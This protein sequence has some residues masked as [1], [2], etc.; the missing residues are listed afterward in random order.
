MGG[1]NL[2][3]PGSHIGATVALDRSTLLRVNR[4]AGI[5]S[6][7]IGFAVVG[8]AGV[9][10]LRYRILTTQSR[11]TQGRVIEN[12]PTRWHEANRDGGG[13]MGTQRTS[14]CA[15]VAYVD[16]AGQQHAYRDDLCMN[17]PSFRVGQF[18]TV[19]YDAD[20]PAQA[21]IDRGSRRYVVPLA[22]AVFG[23]LCLVGG[24]QR[25]MGRGIPAPI[26]EVP[27]VIREELA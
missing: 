1:G 9:W 6:V 26:I 16:R 24:T 5:V 13:N 27:R 14:Y 22:I 25:L 8:A 23:I 10:A 17:P 2:V 19:F 21:L 15:V 4:I 18:V 3:P 11:A 7:V 12:V 20:H